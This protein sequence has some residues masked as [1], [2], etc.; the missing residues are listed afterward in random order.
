M[1]LR[2]PQTRDGL[3]RAFDVCFSVLLLI[4]VAPLMAT[5]AAA[6]FLQDGGPVL[7]RQKRLG[8]GGRSFSCLKFRTMAV[9]AEDQLKALLD[10][11]PAARGEWTAARKLRHDP[12]ITPVGRFLRRS[13]LDELPQLFNVLAGDMSLVGPRPIVSEEIDRYGVH[14]RHYC[15]V[16]PGL[17]GL[18]QVNGRNNVS[19]RR[20]VVMDV[21]YVRA[22]CLTLDISILAKTVPAVLLQR[23]SY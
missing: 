13:S 19:F 16:R 9:A 12:R 2:S 7:F 23:G 4:F 8:R 14:Y 5:A 11:D 3:R 18:W 20:R 15:A 17:T 22:R 10:R 21:A 6:I 1:Q